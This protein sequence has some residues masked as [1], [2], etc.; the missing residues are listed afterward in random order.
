MPLINGIWYSRMPDMT[1]RLTIDKAGRVVIPKP[2]RDKLHLVTGDTIEL[3]SSGEQIVLRP[4]RETTPLA[5]ERGVWV[6]RAGRSITVADTNAVLRSIRDE[7]D[8]Q[9]L[10]RK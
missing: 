7:R 4:V 9:N 10:G 3:E 8:T 5:K 6:Y 1:K 2:I